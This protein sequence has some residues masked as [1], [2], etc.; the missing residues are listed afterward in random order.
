M[1]IILFGFKKCGKTYFGMQLAQKL[2]R[3]F[4]DSDHLIEELYATQ[5]H[6]T[7]SYRDIAKKHGFSFFCEL[8]KHVVSKLVQKRNRVISLGGGVMLNPENVARLE[9][10]GSLVYL[11]PSK[12]TLKTRIL[13][14][15]IPPYLDPLHP[16]ESFEKLYAERMPVYESIKAHQVTTEGKTEEAILQELCA[17]EKKKV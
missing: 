1:N 12:M 9:Q 16:G 3:E 11:K 17:V 4:I 7:L 15:E 5:Y 10:V 14:G 8:E 2:H 6:E 13:S